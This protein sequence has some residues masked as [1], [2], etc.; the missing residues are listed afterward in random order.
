L[1]EL[2]TELG[3]ALEF[4]P[5]ASEEAY[6]VVKPFDHNRAAQVWVADTDIALGMVGE[7]KASVRKSLKLPQHTAGFSIGLAQLL[8]ALRQHVTTKYIVLPRFPKV[9]QDITFKVSTDVSYE[10]LYDLVSLE[11]TKLQPEQTSLTLTGVDIYQREDDQ[12][13]KQITLRLTIASYEKTMRDAEVT[14]ML[15]AVAVIAMDAIG[16]ERI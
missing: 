7:Y 9:T 14:A 11:L 4:R 10:A 13:H 12:S 5:F 6:P 16:A 15:D 8:Q 2:A 1:H 3:V